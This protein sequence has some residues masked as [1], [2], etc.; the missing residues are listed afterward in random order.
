LIRSFL[1]EVD[2]KNSGST[3]QIVEEAITEEEVLYPPPPASRSMPIALDD[4]DSDDFVLSA[5]AAP[6]VKRCFSG[7]NNSTVT[8]RR[9]TRIGSQPQ[10]KYNEFP[11]VQSQLEPIASS[12]SIE[13]QHPQPNR[14]QYAESKSTHQPYYQPQP[15]HHQPQESDEPLKCEWI[16]E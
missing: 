13:L 15:V 1:L 11:I 4:D 16:K 6:T 8:T 5:A 14:N 7:D 12:S 3:T 2:A 9:S 10:P